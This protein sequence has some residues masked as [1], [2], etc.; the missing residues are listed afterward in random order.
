MRRD[1]TLLVAVALAAAP[2]AGCL[3]QSGP[4]EEPEANLSDDLGGGPRLP[5]SGGDGN[6]SD[7][8]AGGDDGDGSGDDGGAGLDLTSL[9]RPTWEPG[10]WW[11]M[12]VS[13]VWTIGGPDGMDY[14]LVA[15]EATDDGYVTRSDVREVAVYDTFWDDPLVGPIGPDLTPAPDA[16][17]RTPEHEVPSALSVGSQVRIPEPLFDWPLTPDKTWTADDANGTTWSLSAD[18]SNVSVAGARVEGYRVSGSSS[19]GWTLNVTYVPSLLW[20]S[21]FEVTDPN[22]VRMIRAGI[23]DAGTS[24]EGRTF[25]GSETLQAEEVWTSTPDGPHR[26]PVEVPSD[27]TDLHYTLTIWSFWSSS[28]A[29]LDPS[30]NVVRQHGPTSPQLV[31]VLPGDGRLQ[32]EENIQDPASGTWQLVV[33]TVAGP[34]AGTNT[35]FGGA[36]ARA[37]TLNVS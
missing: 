8:G 28:A 17:Y 7:D 30:G 16:V 27:A 31:F 29:L 23:R 36:A 35:M 37:S 19:D 5:G 1:L 12:N 10:Y 32:F 34:D 22:D 6:G 21:E 15:E 2:L 24:F 26:V 9:D 11:E 25:T 33:E 14:T 20:F 3:G 13:G 4:S 18:L